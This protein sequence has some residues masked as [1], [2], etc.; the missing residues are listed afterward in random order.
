MRRRVPAHDETFVLQRLEGELPRRGHFAAAAAGGNC[1]KIGL[2]GKLI[3]SKSK[4][5]REVLFS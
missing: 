4:G 1:I 3:F 5:L 2:P